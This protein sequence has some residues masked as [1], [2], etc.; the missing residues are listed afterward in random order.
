MTTK[1]EKL[2]EVGRAEV[3]R[4]VAEND[5]RSWAGTGRWTLLCR[6]CGGPCDPD[7]RWCLACCAV[8]P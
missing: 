7:R 8:L 3:R 2:R 6:S 1:L 5:G 4:L